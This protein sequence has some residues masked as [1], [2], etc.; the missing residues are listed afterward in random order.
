MTWL[1]R[2]KLLYFVSQLWDAVPV[3]Q[4]QEL[5]A[6]AVK[7]GVGWVLPDSGDDYDWLTTSQVADEF[8]LSLASVRTN[9]PRQYGIRPMNDRWRR[10][11]VELV[12]LK[13]QLSKR[14][15]AA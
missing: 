13:R 15:T 11:D 1:Q 7:L 4:R 12:R 5:E 2:E 8:G 14:D 6:A 10:G 9:W 3:E